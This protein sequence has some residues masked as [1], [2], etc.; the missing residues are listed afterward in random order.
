MEKN[1]EETMMRSNRKMHVGRT[2]A[3][4]TLFVVAVPLFALAASQSE[5]AVD[6]SEEKLEAVAKAYLQ[7]FR[8]EQSY[9]PRIQGAQSPDEAN[10]LQ[11]AANQEMVEA[12]ENEDDVTVNE[13]SEIMRAIGDDEELG[14]RLQAV[15]DEIQEEGSDR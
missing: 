10:Q 9:Q 15:V 1:G 12:I 5:S 13:Y 4:T 14:E 8:I 7:V 3:V 6:V 2:L 11:Q